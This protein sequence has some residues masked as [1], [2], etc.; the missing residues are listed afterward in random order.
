MDPHN[1]PS[2]ETDP[3]LF[4]HQIDPVL[5]RALIVRLG[6][7]DIGRAA[8]LDER[9]LGAARDGGWIPL[10]QLPRFAA[11]AAAH[12][13]IFHI[14]HCGSTLLSRLLDQWP[15][16]T[17]LREPLALRN[18]SDLHGSGDSPLARIDP[19]E[20]ST[21]DLTVLGMLGRPF[22]TGDQPVI[23]ATS[24]CNGLIAPILQ[25][26]PAATGVFL[27]IPL[28][29]Y[30]AAILKSEGARRDALG[31]AAARLSWLQ[32]WPQASGL[33]LY[34]MSEPEI[35]AMGW[36]AEMKRL[37][38]LNDSARLLDLD[39]TRLLADPV[40]TLDAIAAHLG[41]AG[42]AS[43]AE[44]AWASSASR[45]Y[46]KASEHA[47]RREDREHDLALSRQRFQRE[48]SE[49]LRW[50]E[51]QDANLHPRRGM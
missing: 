49:G 43:I 30:L 15:R 21:L 3:T 29:D 31:F 27:W 41:L 47:Y 40:P 4:L 2:L 14:G 6:R 28:A 8:F 9:V 44:R 18:L 17:G 12:R 48:I 22:R 36:L 33:R 20:L 25:Q 10:N 5:K 51:R 35:I 19:A 7:D 26:V 23:K 11:S 32:Q 46:A 1:L 42:D 37:D 16:V 39:F 38:G 34:R 50:L 24:S 45:Q 13:F